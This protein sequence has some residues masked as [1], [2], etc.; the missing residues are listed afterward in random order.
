[1]AEAK[2]P[3][4]AEYLRFLYKVHPLNPSTMLRWRGFRKQTIPDDIDRYYGRLAC[5]FVRR[6]KAVP[7]RL[8]DKTA[9]NDGWIEIGLLKRLA[10]T[11]G[12]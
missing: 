6:T 10:K 7:L 8:I 9:R 5:H 2:W 4:T 11:N 1:M 3:K 12:A